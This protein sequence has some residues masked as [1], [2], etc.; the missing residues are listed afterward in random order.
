MER[1]IISHLILGLGICYYN[2]LVQ[3]REGKENVLRRG[4]SEGIPEDR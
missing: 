2:I 4:L 1:G 3:E